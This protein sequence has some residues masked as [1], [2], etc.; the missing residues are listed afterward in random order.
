[1]KKMK[2][3]KTDLNKMLDEIAVSFKGKGGGP[4]SESQISDSKL[5]KSVVE[6]WSSN[7]DVASIIDRCRSHIRSAKRLGDGVSLTIDR[8]AFR[9][10]PY[11]FK[12]TK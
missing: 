8:K 5:D 6:V 3:E 10:I 11:A 9:G 4:E 1:M 2:N 12:T 7:K